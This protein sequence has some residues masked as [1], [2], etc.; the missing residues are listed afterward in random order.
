L[1][2]FEIVEMQFDQREGLRHVVLKGRERK[3]GVWRM[4]GLIKSN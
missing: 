4:N 1:F 2:A 3:E